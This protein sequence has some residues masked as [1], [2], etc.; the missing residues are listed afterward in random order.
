MGTVAGTVAVWVVRGGRGMGRERKRRREREV[1]VKQ[2]EA[3]RRK[4]R[5]IQKESLK[6]A[7]GVYE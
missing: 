6:M 7:E 3:L 1:E 4:R 2:K 5:E